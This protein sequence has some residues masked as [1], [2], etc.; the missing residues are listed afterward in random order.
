MVFELL[1]D[2]HEARQLKG[3]INDIY[4]FSGQAANVPS[5]VSLR[6][7]NEATKYF[8]IPT[9]LRKQLA[10]HGSVSCQR[11]DVQERTVFV[12]VVSPDGSREC[13]ISE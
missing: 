7:K 8:L 10:I 11:F 1:V 2:E 9:K 13:K 3:E 5:R 4:I 12:Y 6:G